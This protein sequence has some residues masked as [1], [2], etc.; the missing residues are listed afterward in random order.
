MTLEIYLKQIKIWNTKNVG[1][2]KNAKYQ[3]LVESLKMNKEINGLGK[4]VGENILL[5]LKKQQPR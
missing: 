4:Y 1:V 3:D 2:E 5:V